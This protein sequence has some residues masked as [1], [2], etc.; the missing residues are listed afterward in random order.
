MRGNNTLYANYI[1]IGRMWCVSSIF[2]FKGMKFQ[3]L[4]SIIGMSSALQWNQF[5]FV[6]CHQN[7]CLL[8]CFL[9]VLH[10]H[11]HTHTCA[12]TLYSITRS[13]PCTCFTRCEG[14]PRWCTLNDLPEGEGTPCTCILYIQPCKGWSLPF[15]FVCMS[16]SREYACCSL[17]GKRCV[18]HKK[19]VLITEHGLY[20]L[21]PCSRSSSDA[22]HAN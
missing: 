6:C 11:K 10:T 2:Y 5:L 12:L 17:L 14:S 9:K 8:K 19:T 20:L 15:I 22:S 4:P 21:S 13:R 3:Q 1:M 16:G 7:C 18:I